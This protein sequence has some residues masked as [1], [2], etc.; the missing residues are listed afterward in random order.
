MR[1]GQLTE[2]DIGSHSTEQMAW[3]CLL[4]KHEHGFCLKFH[5][6]GPC[7]SAPA[8]PDQ[9]CLVFSATALPF[10]YFAETRHKTLGQNCFCNMFYTQ[11]CL[12]VVLARLALLLWGVGSCWGQWF[13]F[14]GRLALWLSGKEPA[15]QSRRCRFNPWVGKI[16]QRRKSQPTPV[17]LPGES[18]GLGGDWWAT[19][20]GVANS[21]TQLSNSSEA[22]SLGQLFG[23]R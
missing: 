7:S 21:W 8:V 9:G 13:I 2:S 11:M 18:H 17:F 14:Q 1:Y 5:C 20:C 19:V 4:F 6:T 15:C 10:D 16:P 22:T 3:H 23:S 12:S